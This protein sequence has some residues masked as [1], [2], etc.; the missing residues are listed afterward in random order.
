M[1]NKSILWGL[2]C[3]KY[4]ALVLF[5]ITVFGLLHNYESTYTRK[6]TVTVCYNDTV[7]ATDE[8]GHIWSYEGNAEIGQQVKL[9][10][11][12]NHTDDI[13]DDIIKEVK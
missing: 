7:Y 12:D 10:M 4:T 13:T 2:L 11:Y 5:I 9:V 1:K 8:Q 3:I 6:A